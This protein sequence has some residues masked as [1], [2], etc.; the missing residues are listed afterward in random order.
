MGNIWEWFVRKASI[1]KKLIISYMVLVLIPI[2][3]LGCYSFTIA[4]NNLLRQTQET[5]S[6][7][8]DRL[9][10]EMNS[11]FERENDFT[12]YLAYNLE[13]R[14]TLENHAY[15]NSAI[16]Q[17]LNKTVE[18]VLWY[19]ITSDENIKG[20]HIVTP[21][22][23]DDIGS[24]LKSS[25][26][27]E[28]EKWYQEHKEN[29]N[30]R[31]TV[32]NE[33]LFATRTILDTA[34]S[35]RMIGI[36]RTEFYLNHL[37]EPFDTMNYLGNGILVRDAQGQ[38]VY[39]K[40]IAD[41]DL[42]ERIV[43]AVDR[44]WHDDGRQGQYVLKTSHIDFVDWDIYYFIDKNMILEGTYSIIFSTLLMVA[45]CCAL[46]VVLTGILSRVV[47]RRILKLKDQ[48]E[49]IAAG[50]LENPVFT[51]DSDE[52]GIVTNSLGK[53]TVDLNEMINRVY[54]IELE[55][56]ASELTALQAQI[57]PHFLYNC[58]SSIK[59]KA[60]KKG[61][62]DIA[63][64]AGLVAKFYR[65]SLNNGRQVTTVESELENVRAYVEIQKKMHEE[66]FEV[67]Y[68]LDS[69][70][71]D[72]SMPNFLLQPVVEN[73]V[74]HGI[75]YIEEGVRGKII[76]E[77]LHEGDYLVFHIYNNGPLIPFREISQLMDRQGRGYGI[78]NIVERIRLYYDGSCGMSVHVTENLYTCFTIRIYDQLRA[79]EQAD[80]R[81]AG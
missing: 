16:A 9:V 44:G 14:K 63:D 42:Q 54:K 26:E 67:E 28:G 56:K 76:I 41:C 43:Q 12:K 72:Y 23:T 34:S 81:F 59:W 13:F 48:A 45:L 58:L 68:R 29:F 32:E 39:S 24:L 30:T 47:S 8:L 17:S 60:L 1:R 25:K 78:H 51:T 22:A 53:M 75:D 69:H 49:E 71:L 36:L 35:S 52:I 37:L 27:Y 31:W 79:A 46:L 74:K 19:F 20:I 62:D 15:D 11:K 70:G 73:A 50:N 33:K 3:I 6:N 21:Y 10:S 7:N 5:M 4:N 2:I 18:P 55:K 61:D 66:G 57:N 77:F 65:T 80:S 64:I 40:E 38:T